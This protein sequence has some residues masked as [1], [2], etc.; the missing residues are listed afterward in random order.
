MI[1][2]KLFFLSI[3][4][5][6]SSSFA[7]SVDGSVTGI[8]TKNYD[9][10]LDFALVLPFN[11]KSELLNF[12]ISRVL[13]NEYDS[14]KVLGQ[15][16]EI[17]SNIS[18]PRQTE[19]YFLSVRLNKPSYRLVHQGPRPIEIGAIQGSLPFKRTVD[20]I[21]SGQPLFSLINQFDFTSYNTAEPTDDNTV[22]NMGQ[23]TMDKEILVVD[24]FKSPKNFI[25][26]AISLLEKNR[27]YL[28]VDLKL[29]DTGKP[30]SLKAT[31]EHATVVVSLPD[32][33]FNAF[34]E[35]SRPLFPF[36]LAWN[37]QDPSNRLPIL[38]DHL[39]LSS[40]HILV[41]SEFLNSNFNILGYTLR[42]LV[43][44]EEGFDVLKEVKYKGQL[45]DAIAINTGLSFSR[46]Q[47]DVLASA[48]TSTPTYVVSDDD[49]SEYIDYTSRYEF[50]F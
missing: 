32:N 29:L 37:P 20:A 35:N 13:S 31:P 27:H 40:S 30:K 44:T 24:N 33:I 12:K 1:I 41:D 7:A 46:L 14:L 11:T 3:F 15:R 42:Y 10:R 39:E 9:D 43:E 2:K 38:K 8:K 49:F 18:L 19:R 5:F 4:L 36:S 28:P 34:Q 22:L 47:I 23:L 50:K 25:N 17:P 16:I 45:A 48:D 21:R 26:L 6:A